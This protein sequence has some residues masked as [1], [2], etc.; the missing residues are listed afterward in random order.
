MGWAIMNM[1]RGKEL[2]EEMGGERVMQQGK[3]QLWCRR[4][5]TGTREE[6][7][8]QFMAVELG[9]EEEVDGIQVLA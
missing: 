4:Y 1:G 9:E 6:E 2:R 3:E 8:W 7:R 5:D